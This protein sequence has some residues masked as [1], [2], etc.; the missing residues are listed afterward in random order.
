VSSR[1]SLYRKNTVTGGK[2]ATRQILGGRMG[3]EGVLRS[4][5]PGRKKR[6]GSWLVRKM[7]QGKTTK[8]PG[9]GCMGPENQST[10]SF[11]LTTV[12]LVNKTH[13]QTNSGVTTGTGRAHLVGGTVIETRKSLSRVPH[14]R[15]RTTI[16]RG[17][18]SNGRH[19]TG[20]FGPRTSG[21]AGNQ[22]KRNGTHKKEKK[23][24]KSSCIRKGNQTPGRRINKKAIQVG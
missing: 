6:K 7:V 5:G 10:S 2:R 17:A 18:Q 15:K 24:R 16:H 19:C 3:R 23:R 8:G 20:P 11:R 13:S 14:H 1:S 22:R 9:K 21:Q 12:K 4:L